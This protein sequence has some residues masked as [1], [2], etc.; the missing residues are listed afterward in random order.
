MVFISIL[1]YMSFFEVYAS[2]FGIYW[3]FQVISVMENKLNNFIQF[4]SNV[5]GMEGIN[6]N[7]DISL[8]WA[9]HAGTQNWKYVFVGK[10][11]SFLRTFN[12][13][14]ITAL[15]P[16]SRIQRCYLET[17]QSVTINIINLFVHAQCSAQ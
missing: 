2:F 3:T 4:T 17:N 6:Q 9:F 5:D 10:K 15:I 11:R 14:S 12:E 16:L 1:Q 7:H 13:T 8:F